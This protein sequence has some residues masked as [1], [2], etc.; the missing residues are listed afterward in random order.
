MTVTKSPSLSFLKKILSLYC[1]PADN[2]NWLANAAQAEDGESKAGKKVTIANHL[3]Q[4]FERLLVQPM[5]PHLSVERLVVNLG[6]T[7]CRGNSTF[8]FYQQAS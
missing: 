3:A 5:P 4:I 2:E 7:R 1:S 8:M 6:L